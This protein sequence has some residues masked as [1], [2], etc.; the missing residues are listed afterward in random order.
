MMRRCKN[1]E[2]F[3]EMYYF[4]NYD[5]AWDYLKRGRDIYK[6][7][8]IGCNTRLYKSQT[9][10]SNCAD[11]ICIR[12]HNTVI[13]RY[14]KYKNGKQWMSF[15]N[16]GWTTNTTRDRLDQYMPRGVGLHTALN[17]HLGFWLISVKGEMYHLNHG[18]QI[19]EQLEIK[20]EKKMRLE[21]AKRVKE[22]VWR[23]TQSINKMIDSMQ[24][25]LD[26]FY[27]NRTSIMDKITELKA[28]A[29]MWGQ[30]REQ[31]RG[32][33]GYLLKLKS[34]KASQEPTDVL[35]RV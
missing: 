14:Y 30:Q 35:N 20:H 19:N 1:R 25:Q 24:S 12:F 6:G 7:R 16:G 18:V 32:E 28:E 22:S 2:W 23:K 9:K 31:L 34:G 21:H 17:R 5:D 13:V 8:P 4:K 15:Y 29:I 3:T 27:Q 26:S 10:L 11:V 33:V